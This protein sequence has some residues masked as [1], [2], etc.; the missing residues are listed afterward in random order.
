MKTTV[1]CVLIL[2][3]KM[4]SV[5]PA[6]KKNVAALEDTEMFRSVSRTAENVMEGKCP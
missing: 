6:A 3:N 1:A 5:G 2:M 4:Y